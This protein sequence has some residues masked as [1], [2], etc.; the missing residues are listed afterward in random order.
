MPVWNYNCSREVDLVVNLRG[1]MEQARLDPMVVSSTLTYEGA[2][3]TYLFVVN[4]GDNPRPSS[5]ILWE[6]LR[7]N[8]IEEREPLTQRSLVGFSPEAA[9]GPRPHPA[10][11]AEVRERILTQYLANPEGRR[12]LAAAMVAPLRRNWDYTAVARRTFLVDQLPEGALPFYAEGQ[13]PVKVPPWLVPG[14]WIENLET[15]IVAQVFSVNEGV[16]SLTL[17]GWRTGDRIVLDL[18]GFNADAWMMI[19]EPKLGLPWYERLD[20]GLL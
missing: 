7:E 6:F 16:S 10:T 18:R 14:I 20:G 11:V 4:T 3:L 1:L 2:T 17:D 15:G 19:P 5:D 12:T 8:S 13:N 9:V